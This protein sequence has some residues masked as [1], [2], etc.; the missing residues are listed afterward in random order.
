[1]KFAVHTITKDTLLTNYVVEF[2]NGL[3]LTIHGR[4]LCWRGKEGREKTI[5][6]F[7]EVIQ[8]LEKLGLE[9]CL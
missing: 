8:M 9:K 5:K 3:A 1:M 7:E 6:Q 2:D 4:D